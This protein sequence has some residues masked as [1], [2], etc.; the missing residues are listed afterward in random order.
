MK[1][2]SFREITHTGVGVNVL[3]A[4]KVVVLLLFSDESAMVSKILRGTW[5]ICDK[6]CV[7]EGSNNVRT[8]CRLHSLGGGRTLSLE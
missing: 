4:E 2:V 1:A 5:G 8:T 6:G 3:V 7:G